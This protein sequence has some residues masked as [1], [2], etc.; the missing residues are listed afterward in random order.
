MALENFNIVLIGDNFPIATINLA[1]FEFNHRKLTEK[2]RVPVLLQAEARSLNLQILPDRFEATVV[3]S[4]NPVEDAKH[5]VKTVE[6]MFE[7]SGPKS[8]RAVGHNA[9]FVVAG[10]AGRKRQALSQL[11][12]F[13]KSTTLVG[14]HADAGDLHL[15]FRVGNE[16]RSRVA[17]LSET[18]NESVVLD[19][20][21][22][23]DT[24]SGLSAR[25]AVE[26]IVNSITTILAIAGRLEASLSEAK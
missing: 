13:D 19:F 26:D 17:V 9:Q 22:N 7:Y 21:I 10:T 20:N 24:T 23:Y 6:P 4:R 2:L 1:D 11:V 25:S 8:V 16:T 5:L 14:T 3:D 18:P 12:N 15:Y